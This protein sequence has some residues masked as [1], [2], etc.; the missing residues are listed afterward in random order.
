M[1]SAFPKQGW[2]IRDAA[3]VCQMMGLVVHPDDWWIPVN[4]PGDPSQPIWR[5]QV[6]CTDLDMDVTKCHA[7]GQFDHTCDHSMDV[8]VK[9]IEPMW[10]GKCCRGKSL[11]LVA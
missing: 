9:C 1:W 4:L 11:I 2:T 7:D 6:S 5:S 3:V 10:A 8:Y